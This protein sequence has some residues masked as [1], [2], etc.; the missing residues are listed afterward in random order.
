MT[1]LRSCSHH[2]CTA[3]RGLVGDD[4][5][6]GDPRLDVMGARR[7]IAKR[8]TVFRC[9]VV[10]VAALCVVLLVMHARERAL[11]SFAREHEEEN[12]EWAKRWVP[13]DD[14]DD[15]YPSVHMHRATHGGHAPRKAGAAVGQFASDDS[16]ILGGTRSTAI[17]NRASSDVTLPT[18][19]GAEHDTLKVMIS[20]TTADSPGKILDW[21]RYHRLLGVEHFFLFVEGK[22]AR[23]KS[24]ER[25]VAFPGVTV[26]EPSA[27]LDELRGKSRAWKEDWLGNFFE[28]PCNNELFVRQSLNMEIAIAQ[29]LAEGLDWHVHID[30]DELLWPGGE[31]HLS[32][33]TFLGEVHPTIDNVV[34]A[35]Y[36]AC[37][38]TDAVR[39]PFREVTLFKRNFEHVVKRT[40]MQFYK[41]VT[42]ANPNYFLTYANGKSAAR[43]APGLRS[44]GAHRFSNYDKTP[45]EAWAA[46]AA[47]LH[48]TYTTFEDIKARK[49]RC[50]CE[51]DE[52]SLKKC[53]ILD[54]DRVLYVKWD[55]MNED[56]MR[57]FY[58]KRVVWRDQGL[59]KRLLANGLFTRIYAPQIIMDGIRRTFGEPAGGISSSG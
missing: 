4:W 28:K 40:Y 43:V 34:F 18:Q 49:G 53:F 19:T 32:M 3:A 51:K 16:L 10:S 39:D 31:K 45:T 1:A 42:G 54:F 8:R 7:E 56:E 46:E 47:V 59:K 37:P 27:E 52:E 41:A 13:Q 21:M 38:E 50:E 26:W 6:R 33:K 58:N 20:T 12:R 22:A 11:T 15:Q 44:N 23:K 5:R 36:E 25:L 29:A 48:Y 35:N 55:E 57:D 24:V 30:V 9:F 17:R 2:Q 14:L